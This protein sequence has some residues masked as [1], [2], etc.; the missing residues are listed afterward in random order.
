[1]GFIDPEE[2]D[3]HMKDNT[4]V[5]HHEV[6]PER[7]EYRTPDAELEE[8]PHRFE[9][10]APRHDRLYLPSERT[11]YQSPDYQH[12]S[13]IH[14]GQLPG[15]R[16]EYQPPVHTDIYSPERVEYLPPSLSPGH[17]SPYEQKYDANNRWEYR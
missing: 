2:G 3:I 13:P 5:S 11:E 8:Y 7:I 10:E 12:Q 6:S 17:G 15:R 9:Y 4:G 14:G 1:M 16:T